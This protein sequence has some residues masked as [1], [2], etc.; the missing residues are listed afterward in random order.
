MSS[1]FVGEIQ[2]FGFSFN[3]RNWAFCDGALL[4]ISQNTSL[5]SLLGTIYGGNGQTSFQLPNLNGRAACRQGAGPGLSTRQIGQTFG[6]N[7]VTLTSS[8]IPAHS[9]ALVAYSQPDAAL[10]SGAPAVNSS[11]STLNNSADRPFKAVPVNAKL[12]PQM[13]GPNASPNAPHANQQPYLAV[14]F[15][16]ALQGVYPTFP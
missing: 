8:Q 3:P 5:F 14:N 15:C 13:I 10:K 12:A 9:H 16:I 2:I 7:E 6:N 4:P 11:F 1:P